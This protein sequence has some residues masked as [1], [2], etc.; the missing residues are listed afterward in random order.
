[1][2]RPDQTIRPFINLSPDPEPDLWSSFD[3]A[4]LIVTIAAVIAV[5][6]VL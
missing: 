4:I 3:L 6:A 1:M 2:T 5:L